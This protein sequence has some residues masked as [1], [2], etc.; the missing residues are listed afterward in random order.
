MAGEPVTVTVIDFLAHGLQRALLPPLTVEYGNKYYFL[1][2]IVIVST[3]LVLFFATQ[4]HGENEPFAA[5]QDDDKLGYLYPQAIGKQ[6]L[7]IGNMRSSV[8]IQKYDKIFV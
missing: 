2:V 6:G 8:N 3:K 5:H 4:L 1:Y 7:G